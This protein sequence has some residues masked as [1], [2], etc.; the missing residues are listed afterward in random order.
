M[1]K[2]EFSKQIIIT[3]MCVNVIV[4]VASFALMWKFG[5]LTPLTYVIPSVG[6]EVSS[7]T[8]FYYWKARIENKIKLMSECGASSDEIAQTISEN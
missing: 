6:V 3:V 2:I 1:K 4:L 8:G 7:A 5:D